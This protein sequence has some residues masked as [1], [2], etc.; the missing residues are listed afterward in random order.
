M[1]A[2]EVYRV[3]MAFRANESI[4]R[5]QEE[6]LRYLVPRELDETQREK[7]REFVLDLLERYGPVV[8]SYPTWHPLVK[9][10]GDGK[11]INTRP[12]DACGYKA[13]D[14]TVYLKDG[15]ITCPYGDGQDVIDSVDSLP[16]DPI[17]FIQAKRLEAVLYHPGTTPI[18]VTC[19]WDKP[20][21]IDGTIPMNIAVP[22]L[23]ESQLPC[24]RWATRGETWESMRP[25]F[26]GKPCGK[27]SSLFI[28]QETGSA[29]KKMW[30]LFM[31]TGAFGPLKVGQL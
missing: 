2:K 14:H 21:L 23:L 7:S 30:T 17:A 15:F 4:E 8:D 13:L 12:G 10:H 25:Y 31:E 26:L 11:P 5:G 24:W 6:A 9:N 28:N 16:S 3:A 20:N 1:R 18:L 29:I 27:R 19:E 22:L